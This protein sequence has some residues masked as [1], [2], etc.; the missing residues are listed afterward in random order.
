MR[1]FLILLPFVSFAI[2]LPPLGVS[3]FADTEVTTNVVFDAASRDELRLKV[4]CEGSMSNNVQVALGRD[5][6]ENGILDLEEAE[7]VFG[8]DCGAWRVA[9]KGGFSSMQADD[10]SCSSELR[11]RCK[12]GVGTLFLSDG[13]HLTLPT[14]EGNFSPMWNM[15]RATKRGYNSMP[16]AISVRAITDPVTILIR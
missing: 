12:T 4:E 10:G 11:V 3:E 6:N 2:S 5:V 8:W 1:F 16:E 7:L 15:L 9:C 13:R 14:H